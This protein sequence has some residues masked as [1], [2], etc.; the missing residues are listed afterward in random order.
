MIHEREQLGGTPARDLALDCIEAGIEAAD[1]ERAIGEAISLDLDGNR[2]AIGT[3][4]Y[5]LAEYEECVVLGGGNA[6]GRMANAI[7]RVL[8]ERISRGVVVTDAPEEVSRVEVLPGD[9][10]VP[11]VRGVESTRTMLDLADEIGEETLAI[12]L[13]SGGGSA[14]MP[15]PA[16]GIS[17]DSL[18]EVTE[19]LLASGAEIGEI[20]AVRKHCSAFKGGGLAHRTAPA[21]VVS[22]I[23]S[24]VI[25]NDLSTIASGPTAPDETTVSDA[26]EV[27]SRYGIDPPAEIKERLDRGDRGEFAETPNK[28]N[29][30]FDRVTNHVIADGFTPLEAIGNLARERGYD[31][32][33]LSSSVRGEAREAAKTHVAIAE[34]VRATGNPLTAPAVICSGGETTVTLRG[35]GTGGPNQEFALS[36]GIELRGID[37]VALASIDT[38]G[39]DGATDAA[40]A[41]VDGGT[42]SDVEG[43]RAAL[44]DNDAYLYL[45][46]NGT[47][48]A[49]ECEGQSETPES[50]ASGRDAIIE[51]GPTGTNVNDLRVLVVEH[52]NVIKEDTSE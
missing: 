27:L 49:S 18:Q 3:E 38:D 2:L 30:V 19:S 45:D 47:I 23:V 40:G 21:T 39:I 4:S 14:L 15:A 35:D 50:R 22:L 9:H 17:L 12:V 8:G 16:D 6:G 44:A 34:E 48:G 26:R 1:P 7:E 10:P 20:N 24:D 51:T 5:D 46:S 42:V 41:I 52:L 28:D 37:G 29:P 13:I 11:S 43:A 31:P 33:I 32:L 25:G 36:A